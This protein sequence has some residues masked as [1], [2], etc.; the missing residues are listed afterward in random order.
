[1]ELQRRGGKSRGTNYWMVPHNG[2][3][4]LDKGKA[5]AAGGRNTQ[6]APLGEVDG[7]AHI[8]G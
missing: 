7:P 8:G 6:M 4:R 5:R 2:P 3:K 1:M